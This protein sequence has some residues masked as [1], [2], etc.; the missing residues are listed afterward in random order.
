MGEDGNLPHYACCLSKI[1]VL[2]MYF[3]LFK[4]TSRMTI[5]IIPSE[6]V[7]LII[8]RWCIRKVTT[9]IPEGLESFKKELQNTIY[10]SWN[11]KCFIKAKGESSDFLKQY[12]I[13]EFQIDFRVKWVD[14]AAHWYVV[15]RSEPRSYVSWTTKEIFIDPNDANLQQKKGGNNHLQQYPIA[16]EFGHCIGNVEGVTP[17]MFMG[18]T[19]IRKISHGDEYEEEAY[20][21]KQ[22]MPYVRDTYS[23]MNIGYQ[24]RKRHFD[25]LLAELK[26]MIPDTNFEI[27]L[28]L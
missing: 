23:I 26:T 10:R 4:D 13:D 9:T 22:R 19:P 15:V 11:D 5:E 18:F 21:S 20:T 3:S 17:M 14:F 12:P 7:I 6:K 8:Q 1:K 27:S 16:H 24:L 28:L 2:S 25:Y